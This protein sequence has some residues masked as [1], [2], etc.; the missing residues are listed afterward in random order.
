MQRRS[1]STALLIV[2]LIT[3]VTASIANAGGWSIGWG[4]GSLIADGWYA[5]LGNGDFN[6]TVTGYGTVTALCQNNGGNLAP[7]R[8]PVSFQVAQ[9]GT[10][11]ADENGRISAV[12]AAPDPTL[13]DL[14]VSP[15]PKNAGCP[16]STWTVVGLLVDHIDWTGAHVVVS[17]VA[18]G[19]VKHDLS[20]TCDT[21]HDADGVAVDVDCT[22]VQ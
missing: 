19:A 3:L 22:H 5:G 8:N 9:T 6:V 4:L 1:V 12:V 13:V 15:S 14:T 16:S 7:G 21:V 20:F 10:F 11:T 2:I 18:S 17:E